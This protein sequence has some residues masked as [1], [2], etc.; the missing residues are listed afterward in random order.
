MIVDEQKRENTQML[1]AYM[2]NTEK[3]LHTL[4]PSYVSFCN[5]LCKGWTYYSLHLTT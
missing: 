2:L 4:L 5:G 3:K 1:L